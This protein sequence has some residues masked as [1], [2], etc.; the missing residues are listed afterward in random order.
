MVATGSSPVGAY[1]RGV[2]LALVAAAFLGLSGPT[3]ARAQRLS[4]TWVGRAPAAT[5]VEGARVRLNASAQGSRSEKSAADLAASGLLVAPM[6][7]FGGFLLGAALERALG[8]PTS[9]EFC[10]FLY[11]V[12]GGVIVES[13][14]VPYGVHLTNGRRG[15]YLP[16]LL[17]SQVLG[18]A[19]LV[20]FAQADDEPVRILLLFAIPVTQVAS[21]VHIERATARARESSGN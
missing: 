16:A 13:A 10:G 20:A 2:G 9:E 18:F 6:A 1:L 17:V 15:R 5:A 8:C 12:I 4:R 14:A 7:F 11:G 21:S 3:P 19:G